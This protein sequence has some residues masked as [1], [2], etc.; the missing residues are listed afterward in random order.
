[1]HACTY[2]FLNFYMQN[3]AAAFKIAKQLT[4]K[5][6]SGKKTF[7]IPDTGEVNALIESAAG[8]TS[9]F[10]GFVAFAVKK[11]TDFPVLKTLPVSQKDV[12][13]LKA[14]LEA[15]KKLPYAA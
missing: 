8:F 13:Q 6:G 2:S 15:V 7:V 5:D 14:D 10:Q 4:K 9:S 3:L 11:Q 1:M 12:D